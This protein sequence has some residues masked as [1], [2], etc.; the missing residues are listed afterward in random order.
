MH[1]RDERPASRRLWSTHSRPH[2]LYYRTFW[3]ASHN[4]LECAG[5]KL[6]ALTRPQQFLLNL[7]E[8]VKISLLDFSEY[9]Q[10]SHRFKC[11][12][13]THPQL[14]LSN[15]AVYNIYFFL[16]PLST[17]ARFGRQLTATQRSRI[18][19]CGRLPIVS[20]AAVVSLVDLKAFFE[21]LACG[22]WQKI[23]HAG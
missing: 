23:Q 2:L 12:P 22:V 20:T 14:P 1:S 13:K 7:E 16:Q 6:V 15:I 9:Y 17:K 4:I 18:I 21:M 19:R 11:Q 3:N 10:T 8:C 5:Y